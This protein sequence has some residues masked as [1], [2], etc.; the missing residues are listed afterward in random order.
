MKDDIVG[1]MLMLISSLIIIYSIASGFYILDARVQTL[2]AIH[3][4]F[5]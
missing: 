2:E 1:N 5:K 3:K 4:T